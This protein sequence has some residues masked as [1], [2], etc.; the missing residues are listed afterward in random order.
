MYKKKKK[1]EPKCDHFCGLSA[2]QLMITVLIHLLPSLFWF[3]KKK[4]KEEDE[5]RVGEGNRKK[6]KG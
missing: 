1:K 4:G 3:I 5:T 2:V 6:R